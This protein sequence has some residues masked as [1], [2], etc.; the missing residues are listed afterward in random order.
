MP[1]IIAVGMQKGGVG[2]TTISVNLAGYLAKLG[3]KTLLID[4]D[5]QASATKF[6]LDDVDLKESM[7]ALF[8][9]ADPW[10]I[11]RE[12]PQLIKETNIE[13]LYIAPSTIVLSAVESG[14]FEEPSR[15]F[16][17]WID[18]TCNEFDYIIIDCPPSLGRLCSNALV[19]AK[20]V[21]VCSEP[22]T[23]SYDALPIFLS[24]IEKIRNIN[25]DLKIAG[26]IVNCLS[27]NQLGHAH[28]A[29]QMREMNIYIGTLHR[30]SAFVD[31]SHERSLIINT[32]V[33][34]I[35]RIKGEFESILNKIIQRTNSN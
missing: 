1:K 12:A 11:V 13:N 2:K 7:S 17:Y 28:Y 3:N 8:D 32:S 30:R 26:L 5:P 20:Y 23:Q 27:E 15:R 4:A 19:A 14:T 16:K 34:N 31:M 6:F 35:S 18:A 10:A 29:R 9:L 33:S 24:N 21:V 25:P 22:E